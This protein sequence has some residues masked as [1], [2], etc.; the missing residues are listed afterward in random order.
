MKG[1]SFIFVRVNPIHIYYLTTMSTKDLQ[2]DKLNLIAWILKLQDVS[3]IEKLKSI[4]DDNIEIPE[5][6]KNLV[7]DRIKNTNSEDYLVWEE[8]E[9]KL[10]KRK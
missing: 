4:Q 3:L 8:V 1:L 7:R 6:H 2:A 5:S 9:A 10:N